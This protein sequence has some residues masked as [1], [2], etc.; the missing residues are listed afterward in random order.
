MGWRKKKRLYRQEIYSLIVSIREHIHVRGIQRP[1]AAFSVAPALSRNS[2]EA[3][4]QRE[5]MSDR[6]LPALVLLLVVWKVVHDVTERRH[7]IVSELRSEPVPKLPTQTA[8]SGTASP[9]DLA[10]G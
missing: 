10:Q 5:I 4:I 9:V 8:S 3:F 6:V 7:N 2:Y 1:E